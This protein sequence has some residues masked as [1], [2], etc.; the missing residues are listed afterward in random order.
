[1]G[2]EQ[3]A[4]EAQTLAVKEKLGRCQWHL[5]Q[6]ERSLA[7]EQL[8][9]GYLEVVLARDERGAGNRAR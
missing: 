4:A 1:M 2:E 8:K 7:E 3:V 6:V 5:Q 9:V